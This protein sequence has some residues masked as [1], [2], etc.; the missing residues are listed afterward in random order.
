MDLWLESV[1]VIQMKTNWFSKHQPEIRGV[2]LGAETL[3][4]F[5]VGLK[6]CQVLQRKVISSERLER[7]KERRCCIAI[8]ND[9]WLRIRR[10][11]WGKRPVAVELDSS[12]SSRIFRGLSNFDGIDFECAQRSW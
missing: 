8:E 12:T 10:E 2:P 5:F 4:F 11:V 7:V 1:Q 9:L 3:L 6:D